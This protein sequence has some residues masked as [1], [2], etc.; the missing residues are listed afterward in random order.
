MVAVIAMFFT[1]LLSVALYNYLGSDAPVPARL[2][3]SLTFILFSLTLVS[4][5][6]RSR[7]QD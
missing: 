4:G 3:I 6:L 2:L 1:M 5:W 7:S